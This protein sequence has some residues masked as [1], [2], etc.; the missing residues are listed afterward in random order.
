MAIVGAVY[1]HVFPIL[2][3]P[4]G[5]N[6]K[7]TIAE[8]ISYALGSLAGPIPA[9]MLLAVFKSNGS[10]GPTPDIMALRG[11]RV[12][13]ASETEDGAKV[14]AAKCKWLTG[15]DSL[16]GRYPHDRLP[17]TFEPSHTLFLLTNFLPHAD[18]LDKAF[19]ERMINIPFE[20]QFVKNREP[21]GENE[22][23]AYPHLKEKLRAE[24]SGILAWLVKGCLEWQR[25]G[26]SLPPRVI[27][28]TENYQQNEDN[29]TGLIEWCCVI[30]EDL[31]IGATELY[32][33]FEKWWKKL[34]GNFPPKQKK[35]G[36]EMRRRFTHDKVGGVYKYFGIELNYEVMDQYQ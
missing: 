12:A 20:Y 3:G 32:N 15:G 6:G 24:A 21:R 18:G 16:T 5:R 31:T 30:E 2:T 23:K 35:F 10:S 1:E 4:R 19:W 9:E 28:E 33:A 17:T 36:G 11:L 14:S 26:L 34:V 8:G 22:R 27:A 25:I 13:W 7:T 29:F